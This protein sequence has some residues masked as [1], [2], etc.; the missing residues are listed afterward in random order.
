MK[1]ALLRVKSAQLGL[2]SEPELKCEHHFFVN[3]VHLGAKSVHLGVKS[4]SLQ[5]MCQLSAPLHLISAPF[6][7]LFGFELLIIDK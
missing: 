3:S 1:S 4:V 5:D 6:S 2:R 7:P